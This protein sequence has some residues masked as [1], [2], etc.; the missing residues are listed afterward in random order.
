M[1]C[2]NLIRSYSWPCLVI[3]VQ[4]TEL[5]SVKFEWTNFGQVSLLHITHTYIDVGA[6]VLNVKF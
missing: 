2:N 4:F 3:Q 6:C 1:L 5:F